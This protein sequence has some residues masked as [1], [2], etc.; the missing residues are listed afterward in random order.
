MSN[1]GVKRGKNRLKS[2]QGERQDHF[3]ISCSF[4]EY[5]SYDDLQPFIQD[6]LECSLSTDVP[7]TS[8][9]KDVSE[10][11]KSMGNFYYLFIG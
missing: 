1:A 4:P 10:E 6:E 7:S 3:M 5:N 8:P 9:T 2:C 11:L